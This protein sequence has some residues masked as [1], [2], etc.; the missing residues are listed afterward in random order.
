MV[1]F[2]YSGLFVKQLLNSVSV[3]HAQQQKKNLDRLKQL[4]N[5]VSVNHAQ[6]IEYISGGS[7][8]SHWGGRQAVGGAPTSDVGG[9][10]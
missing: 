3:N 4:L 7:R 6:Q 10:Q 9:F 2:C 1:M 8:I 5:S